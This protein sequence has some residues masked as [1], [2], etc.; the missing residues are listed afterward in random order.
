MPNI[1]DTI[2]ALIP[3]TGTAVGG[4]LS[5]AGIDLHSSV[6]AGASV[7]AFLV[8]LALFVWPPGGSRPSFMDNPA[9]GPHQ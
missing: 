1:Y 7:A 9:L 5:L 6:V 2:L 3:T 8:L 4:L